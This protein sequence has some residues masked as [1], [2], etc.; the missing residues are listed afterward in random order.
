MFRPHQLADLTFLNTS[1][2]WS[3]N[4]IRLALSASAP[5]SL[6]SAGFFQGFLSGY[7]IARLAIRPPF[8]LRID[9]A[10]APYGELTPRSNRLKSNKKEAPSRFRVG[11]NLNQLGWKSADIPTVVLD[12]E[13]MG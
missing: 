9:S 11:E 3:S 8:L 10:G 5:S 1:G 6:R 4:S 13:A 12:R 7:S 2:P